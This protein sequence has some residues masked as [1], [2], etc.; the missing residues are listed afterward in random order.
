[1]PET[2][3]EILA[4]IQPKLDEDWTEICLRPDLVAEFEELNDKLEQAQIKP[5]PKR[6]SDGTT[7]ESRALA[8][9]VEALRQQI[10]DSAVTF[11][12]R[13]L[14]KDKFRA[15]CDGFPPRRG[16]QIDLA[17]GYDRAALGDALVKAALVEPDFDDESWDLLV[18]TITI[19]EWNELRRC[20][21]KVN[22]SV[23]TEAPKA[24]LASRILSSAASGSRQRPD[25]E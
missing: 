13:G 22:G 15:L 24:G 4:R 21:E 6:N 16:D 2:G 8:K 12:F 14:P 10:A 20:A 17:V 7:R 18:G 5:G 9:Q 3:A 25:S 23:V 11:R 1:M 19:G